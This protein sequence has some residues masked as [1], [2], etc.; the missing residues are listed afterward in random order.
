MAD[1]FKEKLAVF[2]WRPIRLLLCILYIY[3]CTAMRK[4]TLWRQIKKSRVIGV[5]RYYEPSATC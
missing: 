2:L 4:G 3:V 5:V 1:G